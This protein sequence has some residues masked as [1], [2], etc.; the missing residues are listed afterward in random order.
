MRRRP[1]RLLGLRRR[2]VA[3]D[4]FGIYPSSEQ[5]RPALAVLLFCGILVVLG[6]ALRSGRAPARASGPRASLL[7]SWLMAAASS[8]S[9]LCRPRCGAACL[10]LMLAVFGTL[11]AFPLAVLLALGRRSELPIVRALRSPTSS[12]S[13]ACR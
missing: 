2:Q 5:W 11:L 1:R 3:P 6:V 8:A 13:A 4:L 7:C 12:W 9:R 10:T